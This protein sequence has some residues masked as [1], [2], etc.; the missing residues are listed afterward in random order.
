MKKKKLIIDA[1]GPAYSAASI[2]QTNYEVVDKDTGK[3]VDN[4][5][6]KKHFIEELSYEDSPDNYVFNKVAKLREDVNPEAIAYSAAKSLIKKITNRWDWMSGYE[7]VLHGQGNFREDYAV[8]QVYKGNRGDKP[9]LIKETKEYMANYFSDNLVLVNGE[10]ADDYVARKGWEG[11]WRCKDRKGYSD[12]DV[13]MVGCDKDYNQ[14]PGL[15]YDPDKN[16]LISNTPIES[17]YAFYKQLLIGDSSDNIP[18]VK[19]ISKELIEKYGIR[20]GTRNV[21]DATANKILADAKTGKDMLQAVVDTYKDAYEKEWLT[22]LREVSILIYL[23]R[24]ENEIYDIEETIK[25]LGVNT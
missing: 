18:N 6:A 17:A 5:I 21:G 19:G 10:E 11:F 1:D 8:T 2:A 25:R 12:V 16:V 9:L 22:K 14:V 4:V 15:R 13:C 7:V 23:R 24:K 20:K 3:V